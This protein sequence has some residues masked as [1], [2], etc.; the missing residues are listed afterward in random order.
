VL[1]FD[2]GAAAPGSFTPLSGLQIWVTREDPQIALGAP[3][4]TRLAADCG[5]VQA[6]A[7]DLKLM[8]AKALGSVRTDAQGHAQTPHIATGRYYLVGIFPYQGHAWVWDVPINLQPGENG[9]TLD[10]TNGRSF[11]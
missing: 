10:Q 1:K 2:V 4:A 6:C 11:R 9:V 5:D 3:P 7:Q 8:T